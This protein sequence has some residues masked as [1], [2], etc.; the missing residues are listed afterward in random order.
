[1]TYQ[2]ILTSIDETTYVA[3]ITLN[4]PEALNALNFQLMTELNHALATFD[5]NPA[6][7]AI[8]I[9]GSEKAFAAGADIKEMV[10][11]TPM[12][13]LSKGYLEMWDAVAAIHKPTIAA[14]SGY[15]LG[16][17]FELA[18][19]CDI[20]VASETA[21]FGFPEVNIGVI[22]GAGGTQRLSRIVGTKKA[23]E[24]ILTG[25]QITAA[26]AYGMGLINHV[27][28]QSS[29]LD[30]AKKLTAEIA[31]KAPLA[32]RM[33]KEAVHNSDRTFIHSGIELERRLFSILFSTSDMRE[34]MKAF[35][36]KR[37]PVWNGH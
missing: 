8:L 5:Q 16:G 1:M 14:V 34:G 29:Y 13:M 26:D 33:A 4:R 30:D 6:V 20:L 12:E 18:L 2:C 9:S 21:K 35:I 37:K 24:L 28:P 25:K 7:R 17:G 15:A 3:S 27:Y 10:E 23:M 36:E 31:S 22:P 32:V 19:A 11:A